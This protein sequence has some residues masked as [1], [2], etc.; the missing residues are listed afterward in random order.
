MARC[1][2]RAAA[3]VARRNGA[4][5]RQKRIYLN[6][7]R[8]PELEGSLQAAPVSC[9]ENPQRTLQEIPSVPSMV[10]AVQ[11]E[12]TSFPAA[13]GVQEHGCAIIRNLACSDEWLDYIEKIDGPTLVI[14][15]LHR[16]KLA[17]SV[18]ERRAGPA[19]CATEPTGSDRAAWQRSGAL[20]DTVKEEHA[21][22]PGVCTQAC[23]AL[24]NLVADH[25]ENQ[26]A[27]DELSIS[28]KVCEV[29][30]THSA[31]EE[32][33]EN[34]YGAISN[35]ASFNQ[36]NKQAVID[37]NGL[38]SICRGLLWLELGIGTG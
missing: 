32:L 15:A 3:R 19:D 29:M 35:L 23:A 28:Q 21:D 37:V 14:S 5:K 22:K 6:F 11:K 33:L 12:M 17:A 2:A 36:N 26:A 7:E 34:A 16:F 8:R 24:W 25:Q 4:R 27:A 20:Q 30:E 18:Q 9:G 10:A 31:D 38:D 13:R 1:P